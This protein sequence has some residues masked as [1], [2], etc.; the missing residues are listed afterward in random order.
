M[1]KISGLK[2]QV[3]ELNTI[4][5]TFEFSTWLKVIQKLAIPSWKIKLGWQTNNRI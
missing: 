5:K 3:I 2:S 4:T 1:E